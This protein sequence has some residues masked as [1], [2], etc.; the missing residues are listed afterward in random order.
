MNINKFLKNEKTSKSN[1]LFAVPKKDTKD[2]NMPHIKNN[3]LSNLFY[4][5]QIYFI[6]QH[7]NLVLNIV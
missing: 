7:L 6:Y 1:I 2:D 5:K 3:I 4:I